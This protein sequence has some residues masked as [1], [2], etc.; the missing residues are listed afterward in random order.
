MVH[1]QRPGPR[2]RP[3]R[4]LALAAG[5]ALTLPP[6]AAAAQSD[7]PAPDAASRAKTALEEGKKALEKGNLKRARALFQA[8]EELSPA[9]ATLLQLAACEEKLPPPDAGPRKQPSATRRSPP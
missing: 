9:A 5:L 8:S 3:L 1:L 6:A 4:I 2:A 7:E